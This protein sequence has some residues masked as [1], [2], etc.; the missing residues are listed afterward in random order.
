MAENTQVPSTSLSSIPDKFIIYPKHYT[1]SYT[2]P[3]IPSSSS[4]ALLT[5]AIQPPAENLKELE[6]VFF[7]KR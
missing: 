1:R 5:E 3:S 4:V 6:E 2:Y 7:Y